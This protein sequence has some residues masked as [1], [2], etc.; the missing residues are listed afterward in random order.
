[1]ANIYISTKI[2]AA[3]INR[4][5][6][7]ESLVFGLASFNDSI[8]LFLHLNESVSLEFASNESPGFQLL[9]DSSGRC[10]DNG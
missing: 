5:L 3:M 9:Y 2:H 4:R 6:E 8:L 1:M 10:P 7:F